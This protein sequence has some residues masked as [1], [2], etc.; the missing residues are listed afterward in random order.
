MKI[1]RLQVESQQMARLTVQVQMAQ[2]SINAPMRTIKTVQQQRAQMKVNREYPTLQVDME[3]LRNN[4]GLKSVGTLVRENASQ[5]Q[6]QVRQGIKDI[7]N[8]GDYVATFPRSGNP[9][10]EVSRRAMHRVKQSPPAGSAVDPT[11]PIQSNPGS[12][13][14]DWS[15]QDMSITWDDYQN[16][17]ITFEPKPSVDFVLAQE[18]QLEFKVVE[19][20]Y[21][22][23]TGRTIDKAV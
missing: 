6:A 3:S 14:I 18:P 22:A 11:V 13:S 7:E 19:Q 4:I 12:L 20:S 9:I 5:A 8:N 2:L 21:P 23:E 17:I 10:A 15:L 1:R 16:P